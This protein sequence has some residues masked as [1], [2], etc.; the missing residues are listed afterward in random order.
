MSVW[1]PIA[2]IDT[3]APRM[4]SVGSSRGIAVIS[5]LLSCTLTCPST[6]WRLADHALTMYC[7]LPS[8]SAE[9]RSALPSTATWSSSTRRHTASV[10]S[11]KTLPKCFGS[12]RPSTRR[13]VSWLGTPPES[14]SHCR[15]HE[16]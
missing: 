13:K 1:H 16:K 6:R 14:S 8:P 3:S 10:H 9:P 15:S 5:L 7:T 2:S 12:T 11:R 4:S